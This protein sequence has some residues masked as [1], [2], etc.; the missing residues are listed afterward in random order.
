MMET[1]YDKIDIA[2]ASKELAKDLFP[3]ADS[4][5][6]SASDDD[7][8]RETSEEGGENDVVQDA[9][10]GETSAET[11]EEH[12][13][14]AEAAVEGGDDKQ[15]AQPDDEPAPKSWPKDMHEHWK[16]TPKEVREYWAVRE[17][18]MLEGL[19]QYK[20]DADYGRDIQKTIAPYKAIISAQGL[21]ERD[22]IHSLLNA[23]YR[24]TVAPPSQKQQLIQMLAKSYGVD[25]GDAQRASVAPD[26]AMMALIDDMHSIKA[27]IARRHAMEIE[28]ERKNSISTVERFANDPNN[29][30]FNDVADDIAIMLRANP[31]L[32]LEDAYDKA[33]WANPVTRQREESRIQKEREAYRAKQ[34]QEAAAKAKSASAVSIRTRDTRRT[35]TGRTGTVQN[36]DALLAE[37]LRAINS[38]SN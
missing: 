5:G 22:A 8:M 38:R 26:N 25:L 17:K 36:L 1:E 31:G 6:E 30:Y 10:T 14:R 19:S 4:G 15:K 32:K 29:V 2:A 9:A 21:S 7:D 20:G 3:E 34:A 33:V 16:T 28:N 18:Q 24:L 11:D 13:A 35:P 12:D 27:D 37:N 23:H